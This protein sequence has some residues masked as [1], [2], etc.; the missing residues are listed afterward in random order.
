MILPKVGKYISVSS[1]SQLQRNANNKT[2]QSVPVLSRVSRR[3]CQSTNISNLDLNY[4]TTCSSKNL[5]KTSCTKKRRI[6]NNGRNK[7]N[8]CKFT[9]K[10]KEITHSTKKKR[11]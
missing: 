10:Y 8:S 7:I 11:I 2:T 1:S 5:T 4:T 6:S 9:N 3:T